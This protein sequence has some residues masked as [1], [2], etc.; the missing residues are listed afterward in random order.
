[1]PIA[2]RR[3]PPSNLAL[4]MADGPPTADVTIEDIEDRYEFMEELGTGAT[5]AVYLAIGHAAREEVAVKVFADS[6]DETNAAIAAEV[7]LLRAVPR[8]PRIVRLLET[9][10]DDQSFTLVLELLGSD[11]FTTIS[12]EGAL[13]EESAKGVF[14]QAVLALG[15]LHRHGY[16]H[17]DLKA[18]NLVAAR[19]HD[20]VFKLVDF[21]SSRASA[22]GGLTGLAAT[23]HYCAPEVVRSAGFDG[24]LDGTGAPYDGPACDVWSLGVLLYF[25]LSR[26]LP[27]GAADDDDAAILRRVVRGE[28]SFTPA[29]AWSAVS[30]DARD[31]IRKLLAADPA[32]RPTCAAIRDHAWC[33]QAI[34]EVA[35]ACATEEVART[36][37]AAARAVAA[38]DKLATVELAQE[39]W[40][41]TAAA[42]IGNARADSAAA[43]TVRERSAATG[44]DV[45][46]ADWSERAIERRAR[47]ACTVSGRLQAILRR[48]DEQSR[49]GS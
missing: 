20:E 48:R 17:R 4:N 3:R 32:A 29:K 41:E 30:S 28:L 7:G 1:M 36:E 10:C 45:V 18:E 27:F 22:R 14:A 35:A 34:V 25:M 15:H 44:A 12:E 33:R 19:G 11:L 2:A 31:L 42:A 8:H 9:V 23:A 49:A 39:V 46:G 5:S 43:T 13:T 6:S 40:I 21:G 38:A 16:A 24:V 26:R 47:A 37:Q